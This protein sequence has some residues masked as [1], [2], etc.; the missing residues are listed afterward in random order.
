MFTDIA[1]KLTLSGKIAPCRISEEELA[2]EQ[3][4]EVVQKMRS[5]GQKKLLFVYDR[6]YPSV[7]EELIEL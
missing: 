6:G 3:L 4:T 1:T 7:V 5:L 2:K